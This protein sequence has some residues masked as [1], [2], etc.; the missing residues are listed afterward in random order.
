[1]AYNPNRIPKWERNINILFSTILLGYGI[2]GLIIDDLYIPGKRGTGIHF[3]GIATWILF[4]AFLSGVANMMSVVVD[5]YD[6]RNNEK[7][8]KLFS[9]IT[10]ILGW[11]LFVIALIVDLSFY[12]LQK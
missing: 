4:G 9:R 7:N 5:H 3:H 1:M 10:Q 2:F 12:N 8:Y 6:K 11:T